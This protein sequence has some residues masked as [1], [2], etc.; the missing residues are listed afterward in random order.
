MN[1]NF[2]LTCDDRCANLGTRDMLV[3]CALFAMKAFCLTLTLFL[4]VI[5]GQLIVALSWDSASLVSCYVG[6]D[7]VSEEKKEATRRQ[8]NNSQY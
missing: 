2:K 7:F 6:S 3:Q 1:P 4:F 5:E 8:Q